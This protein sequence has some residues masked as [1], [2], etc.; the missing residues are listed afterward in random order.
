MV[1]LG[2]FQWYLEVVLGCIQM[3][4][5]WFNRAECLFFVLILD[6]PANALEVFA[7]LAAGSGFIMVV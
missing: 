2:C 3:V 6:A 5:G 7:T 1:V 4:W